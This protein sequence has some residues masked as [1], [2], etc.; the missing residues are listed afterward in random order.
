MAEASLQFQVL[1]NRSHAC[2]TEAVIESARLWTPLPHGIETAFDDQPAQINRARR[3]VYKALLTG[4]IDHQVSSALVVESLA[5][6]IHQVDGVSHA[7]S[8]HVAVRMPSRHHAR[9][10]LGEQLL[11]FRNFRTRRREGR[12]TA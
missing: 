12:H 6:F 9:E 10:I 5:Y 11:A 7:R 3:L 2:R 8:R 4:R 1:G